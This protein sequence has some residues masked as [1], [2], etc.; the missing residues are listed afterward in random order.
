MIAPRW[1]VLCLTVAFATAAALLFRN[2]SQFVQ[3]VR[4]RIGRLHSS[5]TQYQS[6]LLADAFKSRSDS[7]KPYH[8]ARKGDLQFN[9]QIAPI[10]YEKCARCHNAGG[11]AP[12]QLTSFSEV[13]KRARRIEQMVSRGLMPPWMADR[14]S[15]EFEGDLSLTNQEKGMLEQWLAEGCREG[16]RINAPPP[17]KPLPEWPHG[18]PDAI[19]QPAEA[20]KV[21][22]EG[23]D[24][25]RC[26]VIPTNYSNDRY[27]RLADMAPGN[28]KVVHHMLLFVDTSGA[29]RAL[30]EADPRP[31]FA[32]LNGSG[33][34]FRKGQLGMWLPGTRQRALADGIGYFLPKGT[35]IVMQV[36]YHPDGKEETDLSR[37]ALYFCNKPVDKQLRCM[38]VSVPL[39]QL[40]IPAGDSNVVLWAEQE[41]PGDITVVQVFPHMHVL[42]RE[43]AAAATLP[44]GSTIPIVRISNWDFRWQNS[45]TL[46]TP[47]Q[48]AKGSRVRLEARFDNSIANPLNPNRPPKLVHFG[49]RTVDEMCLLYLLYTVD[50]ER[51]TRNEPA[52]RTYPDGF[53][54]FSWGKL[55]GGRK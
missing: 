44:N 13:K 21:P 48:L 24:E 10:V 52:P 15:L 41:M 43:M 34:N 31:G 53:L 20:Y 37:I 47:L 42:G 5:D 17:P 36:H 54:Q 16:D 33:P 23:P 40:R 55:A 38:P 18:P 22:A 19:L 30:D 28:P 4:E 45:Y 6:D 25:Y 51:L 11:I 2:N 1:I 3:Q 12:F 9:K 49:Y 14:C 7:E 32:G 27:V 50:S 39:K 26:F 35:D 46:K 29:A 8:R